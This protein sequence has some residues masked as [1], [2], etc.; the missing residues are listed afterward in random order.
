ML[1]FLV[2][3]TRNPSFLL[4]HVSYEENDE[5]SR[6]QREQGNI[7]SSRIPVKY[8][9]QN[10]LRN[11]PYNQINS[12]SVEGPTTGKLYRREAKMPSKETWMPH[13]RNYRNINTSTK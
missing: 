8:T 4:K 11:G 5:R 12:H 2:L 6:R 1:L 13:S 3:S 9:G 7:A 10:G